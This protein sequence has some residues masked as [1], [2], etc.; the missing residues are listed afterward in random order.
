[1]KKSSTGKNSSKEKWELSAQSD[2]SPKGSQSSDGFNIFN[3]HIPQAVVGFCKKFMKRNPIWDYDI[4]PQTDY[5][6]VNLISRNRGE[7]LSNLDDFTGV[8]LAS[9]MERV[10]MD[11]IRHS[12]ISIADL[13][14]YSPL[15]ELLKAHEPKGRRKFGKSQHSTPKKRSRS[16][17]PGLDDSDCE[18]VTSKIREDE[19]DVDSEYD[20]DGNVDSDNVIP[21]KSVTSILDNPPTPTYVKTPKRAR[22]I[23]KPEKEKK[24]ATCDGSDSE[25]FDP[26]VDEEFSGYNPLGDIN[27]GTTRVVIKGANKNFYGITIH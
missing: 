23:P 1:M 9:M 17:S 11:N 15:L 2:K 22:R 26:V 8:H 27:P 16:E 13:A 18:T 5:E 24:L 14:N 21:N 10:M 6:R 19:S 25:S 4:M 12:E 3:V 7:N 20:S